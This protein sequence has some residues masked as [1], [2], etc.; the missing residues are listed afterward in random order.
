MRVLFLLV[1]SLTA[2]VLKSKDKSKAKKRRQENDEFPERDHQPV[3][4]APDTS[5]WNDKAFGKSDVP[6]PYRVRA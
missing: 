5:S 3:D 1:A 4:Y 2:I 6:P